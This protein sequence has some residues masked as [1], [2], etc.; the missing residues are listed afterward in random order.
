LASGDYP[1]VEKVRKPLYG[2]H[3]AGLGGSGDSGAAPADLFFNA[4]A[5]WLH[6]TLRGKQEIGK[7]KTS[8]HKTF[9]TRS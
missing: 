6:Q 2:C 1:A 3:I 4:Y 9:K 8:R 7:W 5:V